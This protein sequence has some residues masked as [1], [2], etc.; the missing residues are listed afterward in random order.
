MATFSLASS[1]FVFNKDN[2]ADGDPY[3]ALDAIAAA[4]FSQTELMAEGAIWEP[5]GGPDPK[6]F[7]H[8]IEHSAVTPRTL[9]TPMSEVNLASSI[10]EVRSASVGRIADSLRFFAE[11]GG[12]TAI[13][14]PTGRPG[15]GEAPF[16]PHNIGVAMENAYRSVADLV[17]VARETGVQIALENLPVTGLVC[18]P[19]MT[20]QELRAFVA[21]FP[22]ELVGLCLDTG[23]A[24]IC[25]LDPALQ[26]R[27]A[28]ERLCAL[29]LQDVDG[30]RDCHW[31]PGH[32]VIDWSALGTALAE[33]GFDGAWTVE[34]LS[35]NTDLTAEEV[36]AECSTVCGR[37]ES[38]DMSS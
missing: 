12:Q 25:G 19:L 35:K 13:V 38:D 18:R 11:L 15:A 9:H 1:L 14:H 37:W 6:P 17:E 7:R 29:H 26:A 23:H 21:P 4:G 3:A 32:G 30:E 2:K 31:V 5:S 20:M 24:R 8:A 28:A 33:I 10:E 34:A 36:A 22:A 16:A 27:V